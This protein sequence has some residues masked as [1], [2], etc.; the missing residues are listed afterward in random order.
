MTPE[1]AMMAATVLQHT[2][3][4]TTLKHYVHGQQHLAAR[5]IMRPSTS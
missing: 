3:L 5:N 4:Q 2:S 1:H